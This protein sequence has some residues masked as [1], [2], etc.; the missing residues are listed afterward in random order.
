MISGSQSWRGYAGFVGTPTFKG[1]WMAGRASGFVGGPDAWQDSGGA[2]D[3]AVGDL[4]LSAPPPD[5]SYPQVYYV[6]ICTAAVSGFNHDPAIYSSANAALGWAG[7]VYFGPWDFSGGNNT[8]GPTV[9]PFS[10]G[11]RDLWS[12]GARAAGVAYLSLLVESV[13]ANFPC[14]LNP[15]WPTNATYQ[16]VA[17]GDFAYNWSFASHFSGAT[18]T[19]PGSSPSSSQ[20]ALLFPHVPPSWYIDSGGH[21]RGGVWSV[22]PGCYPF[23]QFAA[24]VSWNFTATSLEFVWQAWPNGYNTGSAASTITQSIDVSGEYAAADAQS[25]A[26]ALLGGSNFDALNWGQQA[27]VSYNGDG[28]KAVAVT[29]LANTASEPTGCVSGE[30]GSPYATA[31]G[32]YGSARLTGGGVTWNYSKALIDVCG[33]YCLKTLYCQRSTPVIDCSAGTVDGYAPVEIDPPAF[34]GGAGDTQ[35][36]TFLIPGCTCA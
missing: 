33:N 16:N 31:A 11:S 21:A 1:A 2:R 35:V 8:A 7:P 14:G 27:T 19:P 10:P 18:Y 12:N 3:F 26:L 9:W 6:Y 24:L 20:N 23:S 5:G 22:N 28:S 34:D 29:S 36:Y 32:G 15:Y 25:E 30:P 17:D 4:V 13:F